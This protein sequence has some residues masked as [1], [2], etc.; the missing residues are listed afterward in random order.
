[1]PNVRQQ[2][3]PQPMKD[4]SNTNRRPLWPFVIAQLFLMAPT[5][6]LSVSLTRMYM[7]MQMAYTTY[8]QTTTSAI[9]IMLRRSEP[10]L[11]PLL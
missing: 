5:A 11:K 3:M 2:R 8:T 6:V 1:M 7:D 4:R 9:S 10:K